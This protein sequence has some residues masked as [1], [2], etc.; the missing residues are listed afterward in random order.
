MRTKD[1][2]KQEAIIRS[3]I[4][5]VNQIGFASSSVGKIAK[6][7]SVSPA[8]IYI[9]YQNKEDLLVS[10]YLGIKE[11]LSKAML[12][13]FDNSKPIRDILETVWLNT[14]E[15]IGNHTELF[16]F[17]EQFANSPFSQL[18]SKSKVEKFFEPMMTVLQKG[19]DLKIIKNVHF[20][21][22]AAYIFYPALILSNK[23]LCKTINL[24]AATIKK[25]FDLAWD[26]IRL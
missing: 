21:M 1:E 26:A 12:K 8:T 18:V 25:A 2:L 3:T 16:Q 11:K 20:E 9:Y 15:F 19:I 24:D 14:F 13:D 22:L 6:D 7:A 4:K 10:T 5:L 17:T 23:K